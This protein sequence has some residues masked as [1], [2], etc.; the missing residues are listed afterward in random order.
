MTSGKRYSLALLLG[1]IIL[2]LSI[3]GCEN[4]M[5]RGHPDWQIDPEA[6][7]H[8]MQDDAELAARMNSP[9]VFGREG[10]VI[11]MDDE[12]ADIAQWDVTLSGSGAAAANDTTR[13]Y[14][15]SQSIKLT[16]G[17][18]LN[19]FVKLAKDFPYIS[20]NL[21]GV[22]GVFVFTDTD[23]WL[24]IEI[25]K[26]HEGTA[27]SYI[28]KFDKDDKVY[29]S[30]GGSYEE[31]IDPSTILYDDS[32]FYWQYFRVTIDLDDSEYERVQLN[33]EA[34]SLVKVF[35][36]SS[37]MTRP[38]A[39]RLFITGYDDGGTNAPIYLDNLVVTVDDP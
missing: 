21:V 31:V 15:G 37:F 36:S 13:M 18:T 2:L 39:L 3:G 28:V 30:S 19:K 4:N 11:F 10:K 26:Q 7:Y 24:K 29:V 8:W 12:G 6:I 16:P 9:Y 27:I 23:N 25:A 17:S 32:L 1:L 22:S 34:I 14:A 35:D 20:E 33:D 5:P 38:D